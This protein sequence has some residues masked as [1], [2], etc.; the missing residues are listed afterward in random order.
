ML[1][2]RAEVLL[3]PRFGSH[4]DL[5]LCLLSAGTARICWCKAQGP[6][7]DSAQNSRRAAGTQLF[8]LSAGCPPQILVRNSLNAFRVM[9][10]T[11]T[12]E[13]RVSAGQTRCYWRLW[14]RRSATAMDQSFECKGTVSG[15]KVSTHASRDGSRRRR[16]SNKVRCNGLRLVVGMARTF[17]KM[18]AS[19]VTIRA[20]AQSSVRRSQY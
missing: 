18:I 17:G 1:C 15:R 19:T 20:V 11:A 3:A 14:V 5:L 7:I 10:S 8:Q 2:S 13:W 4:S 12:I 6:Y 16:S 9:K